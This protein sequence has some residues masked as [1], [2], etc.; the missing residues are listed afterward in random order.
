MVRSC[1]GHHCRWCT[2]TRG[3]DSEAGRSF[4]KI[5]IVRSHAGGSIARAPSA[6]RLVLS[7]LHTSAALRPLN[8]RSEV[9]PHPHSRRAHAPSDPAPRASRSPPSPS[10][11][12]LHPQA[13][14][15]GDAEIQTRRQAGNELRGS[16]RRNHAHQVRLTAFTRMRNH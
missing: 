16:M 1:W 13:R 11:L 12:G 5:P 15:P 2:G 4:P 8:S 3:G 7:S 6:F 14:Q 10:C 9:P